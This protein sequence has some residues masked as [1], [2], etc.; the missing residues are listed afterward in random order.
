MCRLLYV[1]VRLG[2]LLSRVVS[3]PSTSVVVLTIARSLAELAKPNTYH[4]INLILE[5]LASQGKPL[6]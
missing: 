1:I 5:I 4:Y 6:F 3:S 2:G